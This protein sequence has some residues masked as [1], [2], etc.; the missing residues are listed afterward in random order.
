MLSISLS[1]VSLTLMYR[2][3]SL[4]L[5]SDETISS[6]IRSL[7]LAH[8]WF[9][10]AKLRPW[11]MECR[12]RRN[13]RSCCSWPL[14]R[15][16]DLGILSNWPISKDLNHRCSSINWKLWCWVLRIL[17]SFFMC[18]ATNLLQ[19]I[20]CIAF[21]KNLNWFVLIS[22]DEHLM[23]FATIRIQY[24]TGRSKLLKSPN[25]L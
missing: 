17:Y 11:L 3:S 25:L 10:S 4:R 6:A 9:S 13:E 7:I 21:Y 16:P 19:M 5:E 22:K 23:Q 15:W 8:L 12:D 20:L 24:N 2:V 1:T 18:Q 14:E